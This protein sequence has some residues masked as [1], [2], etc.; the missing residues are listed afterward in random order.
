MMTRKKKHEGQH[1]IP[2][3]TWR[4]AARMDI[5]RTLRHCRLEDDLYE[6]AKRKG[7]GNFSRGIRL[8]LIEAQEAAPD[9]RVTV[10]IVGRKQAI[11]RKK[12][13]RRHKPLR[14]TKKK[15]GQSPRGKR[16]R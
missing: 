9:E 16:V 5:P 6:W 1:S 8:V 2:S 7:T 4:A 3:G 13:L 14:R 11:A 10:P 12:P 15:L